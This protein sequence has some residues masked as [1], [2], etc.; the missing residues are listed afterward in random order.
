MDKAT[1]VRSLS[2]WTMAI[3][4]LK[5]VRVALDETIKQGNT[6]FVSDSSRLSLEDYEER[7]KWSDFNIIVP[8]LFDFYHGLELMLKGFV[9]LKQ[10]ENSKLNHNIERLLSEFQS[11]YSNEAA[12]A[13]L[14]A[15]YIDSRTSVDVLR[16]FFDSNRCSTNKFYELLRYPYGKTLIDSFVHH[17]LKHREADSLPFFENMVAD[18]DVICRHAV[19]LGRSFEPNSSSGP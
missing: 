19:R 2:F 12:F 6:W 7:T 16:E 10:T 15:K 14:L 13:S 8:I 11:H 3:Y 4:Y 17:C 18:I 5:L 9:L 1:Y